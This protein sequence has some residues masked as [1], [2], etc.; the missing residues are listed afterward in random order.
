[1]Y[2]ARIYRKDKGFCGVFILRKL[3]LTVQMKY[4]LLIIFP[5]LIIAGQES[6]YVEYL[7]MYMLVSLWPFYASLRWA[8]LVSKLVS[9][10][11]YKL[12]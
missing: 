12:Q 5:F 3:T 6:L 11:V 2:Q 1:M 4:Q 8:I 7:W 9:E 10:M